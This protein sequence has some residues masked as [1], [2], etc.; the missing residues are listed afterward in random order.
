[1]SRSCGG[2]ATGTA[3][4]QRIPCSVAPERNVRNANLPRPGIIIIGDV[5]GARARAHVR[6]C[7]RVQRQ[8]SSSSSTLSTPP[9]SVCA[10]SARRFTKPCVCLH[11]RWYHEMHSQKKRVE[12]APEHTHARA[13]SVVNKSH[14]VH[15]TERTLCVCACVCEYAS[16]LISGNIC[17]HSHPDGEDVMKNSRASSL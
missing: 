13:S 3:R 2:R 10:T 14:T 15:A 8:P 1:M 4:L 5:P 9:P 16:S 11:W 17:V 6:I 7:A 12:C